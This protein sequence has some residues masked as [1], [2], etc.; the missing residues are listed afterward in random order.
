MRIAPE[1]DSVSVVLVGDLN[2]RIFRPDWFGAQGL[3]QPDQVEAAEIEVI[4]PELSKFSTD[5]LTVQVDKTRFIAK[6]DEAPH[7]RLADLV[8]RT[9]LE[10]LSHTPIYMVGINRFVHFP[11]PGL[12]EMDAIGKTL[13]PHDAWG[14]WGPQIEGTPEKHG[15]LRSLTMEQS[16][17]T[18]R[19]KGFIRA[20]VEPS[21]LLGMG[22]YVDVNDHYEV[23][24]PEKAVGA[25]DAANIVS[26]NFE[27]STKRSAWI[28][29]QV[30]ALAG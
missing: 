20:K 4:H 27:S 8:A 19:D 16:N 11:V 30:M 29:D 28:I 13:A 21:P 9:F 1:V 6:T 18:D 5:W 7:V 17:L 23:S 12:A 2:P 15:G 26:Q 14:E 25:T 22:V 3:L 10:F 24:L